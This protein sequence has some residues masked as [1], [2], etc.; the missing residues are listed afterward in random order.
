MKLYFVVDADGV[1]L[2]GPKNAYV[3]RSAAKG[4]ASVMN[5]YW[6]DS[7]DKGHWR[8]K[9]GVPKDAKY[10]VSAAYVE[11]EIILDQ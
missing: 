9:Y 10:P 6:R 11:S 7:L 2:P 1:P 4:R 8:H 5:T 3:T